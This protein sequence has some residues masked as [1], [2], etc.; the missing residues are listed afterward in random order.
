MNCEPNNIKFRYGKKINYPHNMGRKI[1]HPQNN[2][3]FN[4]GLQRRHKS[5]F[6]FMFQIAEIMI[7]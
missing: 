6:P 5:M 1:L 2:E 3:I 7:Y 4:L